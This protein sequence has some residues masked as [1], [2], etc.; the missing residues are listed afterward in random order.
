M[1]AWYRKSILEAAAEL[2]TDLT[3]GLTHST[4]AGRLEKYGPNELQA[5]Q[6]PT[7]WQ[8][9]LSQLKDFLILLLLGAAVISL[10]LGE[11]SDAIVIFLVVVLNTVLGVVQELKAEKALS[12]LE[13]LTAPLAK[14]HREGQTRE[15]AAKE[16][17]PGDLILLEAGDFVPADARLVTADSYR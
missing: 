17:V 2:E 11:T 6:G 16:L 12:A 4:A 15:V 13:E 3:T 14:V 7:V 9:F 8:K 10:F 5:Q 1:P